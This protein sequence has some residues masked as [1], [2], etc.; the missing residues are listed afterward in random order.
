M[1]HNSFTLCRMNMQHNL[2]Q[3]LMLYESELGQN[4][5]EQPKTFFVQK[6]E[7][8]DDHNTLTRWLKKFPFGRKNLKSQ[9]RSD[10]PKA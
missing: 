10:R 1:I 3:K 8:T 4:A 6:G 2:I 7:V 5:V 9:A